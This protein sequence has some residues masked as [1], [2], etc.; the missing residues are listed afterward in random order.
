VVIGEHFARIKTMMN[1]HGVQVNSAAPSTP[2]KITG[3]SGLP[4]AGSEF[5]VVKNEKE[6]KELSEK[7][8]LGTRQ[9]AMQ[10]KR[11]SIESMLANSEVVKKILP[12]ILKADVQ[13]SLEALKTSLMKIVTTKVELMFISSSVGEISESDVALAAASKAAIIGF[14][15]DI[16]SHAEPLIKEKH[17]KIIMQD[18]IYH[19]VDEV[20][21]LM[22]AQLDK[23]AKEEISGK[24]LIKAVFKASALGTIAGCQVTEGSIKRNNQVRIFR[25]ADLIWKG[26]ISSLKR[27]KDDVREVT[28]GQECGIVLQGFSNFLEGDIIE[29]FDVI[30]LEQEL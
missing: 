8:A 16:E 19:V 21:L 30:Y 20:K 25:G 29:G 12:I 5:V 10:T 22:K 11:G 13:G 18:V 15:T 23:V 26:S 1:D 4:S 2:V 9:L 6:A 7:R 3:L 28:K 24:A 27:V 17:V 14:H